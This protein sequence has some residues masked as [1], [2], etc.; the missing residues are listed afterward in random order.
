MRRR[1]HYEG[2]NR[3]LAVDQRELARTRRALGLIAAACLL[4]A[5]LIP[6]IRGPLL[7]IGLF[8]G[9]AIGWVE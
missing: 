3:H 8:S 5:L 2:D 1:R 4:A 7:M 6:P 9:V